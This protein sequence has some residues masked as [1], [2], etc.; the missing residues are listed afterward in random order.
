MYNVCTDFSVHMYYIPD[1]GICQLFFPF[2][3]IYIGGIMDNLKIGK[4]L[5]NYRTQNKILQSD[6]AKITNKSTS[7]VSRYEK[8][9]AEI[10]A[11]FLI[12]FC[13]HF[14]VSINN[15]LEIPL[16]DLGLVDDELVDLLSKASNYEIEKIK[17]YLV[18]T[19]TPYIEKISYSTTNNICQKPTI[20]SESISYS[21]NKSIPVRGYVAAG[22]P[23]E[24]I[25]NDLKTIDIPSNIDA[26]YALIISGNS[27]YPLIKDGDYV[28]VKSCKELNNGDIGVF[29]YNGSVT[30]KKY[31]KN[32]SILKLISINPAFEDFTFSLKDQKNEFIDFTI[33]G[34]VILSESQKNNQ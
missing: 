34:K 20:I 10:P 33:E 19:T 15:F 27:M 23:I 29:Y 5:K 7:A 25:D 2:L 11:T 21:L 16:P 24:A 18:V 6:I 1:M 14:N 9:E 22:I 17:N 31:F 26:D 32:D 30:C 28:F 8:G 12:D 3:G 4:L 13:N